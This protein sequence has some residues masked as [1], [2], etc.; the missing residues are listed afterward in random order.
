MFARWLGAARSGLASRPLLAALAANTGWLLG[1]KIL[2]LAVGL[3]VGALTVRYLGAEQFGLLSYALALVTLVSVLANLG[4]DAI[5]VRDIARNPKAR[6]AILGS[7][8]VLRSTGGLVAL[9]VAAAAGALLD[10][11]A[12][13]L[14]LLALVTALSLVFQAADPIDSWFRSQLRARRAVIARNAAFLIASGARLLLI[15][16]EA[17][18]L[19][20]A[21]MITAEA[22]LSAL[23]LLIA[24]RIEGNRLRD[25][26]PNYPVVRELARQAWPLMLAGLMVSLYMRI[27]QVMLGQMA[28]TEALGIYSAAVLLSEPLHFVPMAIVAS[29]APVLA[30]WHR[31][32]PALFHARMEE[33][34]RVLLLIAAAMALP[35]SL[36]ARPLAEFLFGPAFRDTGPVLSVHVWAVLFVA[37][38]I[39]SSQYLVLEDLVRISAQRTLVG[40]VLNIV[41]N[42]FWI[43]P[44]G[45]LGCAWATLISYAVA[46]VFLFQTPSSRRCLVLMARALQPGRR[47]A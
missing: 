9:G 43:P 39:A 38:G 36:L 47:P 8:F 45:A 14:R 25:W 16:E 4:L 26:R 23:A 46:S 32:D 19:W 21:F 24:Y 28:G 1:E 15:W 13:G 34:F 35:M 41:L 7:A 17:P 3:I 10:T 31:S 40:A 2:R 18:L 27:D 29:V 5:V 37:L 42:L 12:P 33:L 6:D 20:F 30:Q 22:A 44:Y 11:A